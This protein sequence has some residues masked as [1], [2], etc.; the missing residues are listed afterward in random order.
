LVTG[1][2]AARLRAGRSSGEP[3]RPAEVS[4]MLAMHAA[5]RR[6]LHRLQEVAARLDSGSVAPPTVLAGWDAFS[7]RLKYHHQAED[8]DLWPV[9][10]RELSDPDDLAAVAAMTEE[11]RQIPQRWQMSTTR[12][13]EAEI[14][15]PPPPRCRPG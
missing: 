2:G 15:P 10:H 1:A 9:L 5:L 11:H 13:E 8:D 14:C 3:D 6:D 4:F 12:F 7:T